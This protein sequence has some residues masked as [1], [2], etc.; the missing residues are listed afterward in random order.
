MPFSSGGT[1]SDQQAWDVATY[2]NS[3]DR[4]QDPRFKGSVA[5]TRTAYH[6]SADSLYGTVVNGRLLGQ[7]SPAAKRSR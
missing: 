2:M 1:L 5:Q 7:P 6:D 3:H 4:P